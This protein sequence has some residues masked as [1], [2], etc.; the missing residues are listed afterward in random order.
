MT[1]L[2]P[3][4]HPEDRRASPT[5][6]ASPVPA[7]LPSANGRTGRPPFSVDNA[8]AMAVYQRAAKTWD[9]GPTRVL[10][11]KGPVC[12][13]VRRKGRHS[14]TLAV[15]T[16]VVLSGVLVTVGNG[17]LVS[18][19]EGE[20]NQTKGKVLNVGDSVTLYT[21]APVYVTTL[22]GATTGIVTVV[23]LYNPDARAPGT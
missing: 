3:G 7:P 10:K 6:V 13:A 17:V 12:V 16:T 4:V 23:E 1:V 5:D 2:P 22:P 9:G 8:R 15:P 20:A 19:T 21:E 11:R 14:V 18:A